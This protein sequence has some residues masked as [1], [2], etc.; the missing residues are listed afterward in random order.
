M[1]IALSI[2]GIFLP[3]LLLLFTANVLMPSPQH[4]KAHPQANT[5]IYSADL[6]NAIDFDD[7]DNNPLFS[8]FFDT[9]ATDHMTRN[10]DPEDIMTLLNEIDAS[11]ILKNPFF[12][13]TNPLNKRNPL[14]EPIFEPDLATPPGPFV[15]GV[16]TYV[17]KKSRSNFTKDSTN[18]SSYISLVGS[19]FVDALQ[20]SIELL[21][22]LLENP[23]FNINARLAFGLFSNMTVEERQAGFM[24]HT[25]K[26]WKKITMRIMTPLYYVERN[27][28]LTDRE[29]DAIAQE[30]GEQSEEEENEFAEKHFISDRIGM[31]DTR[32]ELDQRIIHAPGLKV[33]FGLQ[34][35]IPTAF[36]WGQGFVGSKFSAPS[37]YPNFDFQ[38]LFCLAENPTEDNAQQ[39]F[40]L[41]NDFLLDS[42]D[43]IAANLIDTPLGNNGHLGLG[44]FMRGKSSLRTL[45]NKPW[46]E[47]LAFTNRI[48]LEFFTPKKEKRFYA[49]CINQ[50]AFENRNFNDLSPAT[51]AANVIFLQQQL[52]E[53][54]F[55]RA[56][57]T[58]IYPGVIFRWTSVMKYQAE[59][60]G[61][62]F[63][64]DFWLQ[65]KERHGSI[66]A[67]NVT[68]EQ[69]NT[70]I[71]KPPVAWQTKFYGGL[72]LRHNAPR[73]T[74]FFSLNGDA[75]YDNRGIGSDYALAFNFEASF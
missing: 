24:F 67:S 4:K 27:F 60:F 57:N 47:Q 52:V 70:A 19:D 66:C 25:Q 30:F 6:F 42:F 59:R 38:S 16:N 8:E 5:E 3:L 36:T 64:S 23:D 37:T 63:G 58:K 39:A 7:E 74:W 65:N 55:L 40:N 26:K 62:Y 9:A 68:I 46:A 33:R 53:R 32:L 28:S 75:T 56:F 73:R 11:D 14:D 21:A 51:A 2:C 72:T 61:V 43:R 17:R 1:K 12:L 34:S 22:R 45:I 54:L 69:L 49:N 71:S 48:S 10:I 50:Q 35:T 18:L 20:N 41:L 15:V 13:Q 31:G 44:I 29:R